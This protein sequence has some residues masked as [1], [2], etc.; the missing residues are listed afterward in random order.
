MLEYTILLHSLSTQGVP[1]EL[2]RILLAYNLV[3]V[4]ISRIAHE[5]E[6]SPLRTSFVMALRDI[7]DEVIWCAIASLS[8]YPEETP[9]HA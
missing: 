3:L 2:W 4:E 5:A 9:S 7:Q 8:K 6:A 1:Q